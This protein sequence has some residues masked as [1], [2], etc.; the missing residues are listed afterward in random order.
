MEARV[1]SVLK[2]KGEDLSSIHKFREINESVEAYIN[3][4]LEKE[5][6][7]ETEKEQTE[8]LTEVKLLY[9]E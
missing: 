4:Y 5:A 7:K 2:R 6:A 1:D 3:R 9:A 8:N